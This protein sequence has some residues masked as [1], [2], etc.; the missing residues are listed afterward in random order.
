MFIGRHEEQR[1]LAD[2][3]AGVR[4]GR[5]GTLVLV[6]E[7]G[8]G[9]T[10]LLDQARCSSDVR[11]VAIAG[12]EPEMCLG[13]AALHRLLRPWLGEIDALPE[14]QSDSLRTAFGR[15]AGPTPDRYL[16]GMATL[17]LLAEASAPQPLLC[18]IDDAQWLD[19]E[20]ADALTFVARRLHAEALGLL[21]ATREDSPG[22][23]PALTLTGL[24]PGDARNL[25]SASV[26]ARVDAQN[27][28][29]T[30][31]P[32]RL[33]APEPLPTAI[34]V[35]VD[36]RDPLPAGIPVRL[37]DAVAATIVAGTGGNPLALIELARTLTPGQLA[38]IAPLP[39]PLPVGDRLETHFRHQIRPLPAL[40]RLLLLLVSAAPPNEPSL[41]WRAAIHLEIAADEID[42]ALAAGI[43]TPSL[44]FRHPLIRSAV[45]RGAEAPER[46]RVHAALAAVYDPVLDADRHAWHRAQATIGLDE[47]VATLLERAAERGGHSERAAFLSRA[48]DLS[49]D[50]RARAARLV[51]AARAHLV[52]GDPAAA[53][54]LLD[55]A[56]SSH[57]AH[58]VPAVPSASRPPAQPESR[59]VSVARAD[60]GTRRTAQNPSGPDLSLTLARQARATAEMYAGHYATAPAMLLEAAESI[61]G[62]DAVLTRRMLFEAM[63]AILIAGDHNSTLELARTVMASPAMETAR[64]TYADLFLIGYATRLTGD[65]RAAVP[66]MRA[67][68]ATL[69]AGVVEEG[70][71]LAVIS[72]LAADDLWDEDAGRRAWTRLEE[73]DRRTGALGTLRTTLAVGAGWELRAGRFDA[74]EALQDEL[75]ALSTLVGQPLRGETQ[76]IEL[77]AWRGRE[78]ETRAMAAEATGLDHFVRN[79]VAILE[80][81]L[82]HYPAALD[83]LKPSFDRDKPGAAT[84]SLHEIVES[85]VR[86][87]DHEAAKAALVRMEERAPVSGTPWG[88]GLLARGRALMADDDHAEAFYQESLELLAHTQIRTEQARSHLLYGEWLRRRRRRAD[89]RSQLRTAHDM[90]AQMGAE[91]FAARAQLEL[92]ATGDHPTP[93]TNRP[94]RD[95][96]PQE[97]QVAALAA[98]GATNSEIAAR[99]FLSTSTVEYHLTRIYR[100]LAITSRRKLAAAL[101]G[102]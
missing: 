5:S 35:R 91:A 61:A 33:D 9:K 18:L 47:E 83:C 64:P 27:P 46:R 98:A 82:G 69:D 32:V 6:G 63:Q 51:A 73:Y 62:V 59:A 40:T 2:L 43:L 13:Y 57:A 15:T 77:L 8:V 54:E 80:I 60:D 16:V 101:R 49:P 89:A 86:G 96:T 38:G 26:P 102:A 41:L 94:D 100:K 88:L 48:A 92:K 53:G 10:S 85:G 37:D 34:P 75:A 67:A 66:L 58:L 12:V 24:P 21:F 31:I 1:A 17:T 74:A 22:G 50:P 72:T 4:E 30:A 52:L 25:L 19:R 76:R 99:L 39:T 14:P 81:S 36:G 7:P 65:Y 84:R 90:F 56:E 95:L 79:S 55:R 11:V 44:D 42:H 3:L 28:I 68:L 97:R 20:S 71:P 93:R 29:P 23:L 78:A 45:Y 87:G 70:P